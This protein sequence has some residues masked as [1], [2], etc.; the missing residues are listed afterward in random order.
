M[1]WTELGKPPPSTSL[2]K[3]LKTNKI[4]LWPQGQEETIAGPL[5]PLDNYLTWVCLVIF[6][7]PAKNPFTSLPLKSS[8]LPIFFLPPLFLHGEKWG[9]WD[10]EGEYSW[11]SVYLPNTVLGILY[12][13]F[14][15]ELQKLFEAD[16]SIY[17]LQME[18]QKHRGWV[19]CLR[20]HSECSI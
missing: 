16:I 18:K 3:Y 12:G 11:S 7:F 17:S 14:P 2:A 8:A 9:H 20:P 13:L 15:T 19:T 1:R 10:R 4:Y 5:E 6:S